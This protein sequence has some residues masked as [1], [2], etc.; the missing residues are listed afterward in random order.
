MSVDAKQLFAHIQERRSFLCVGL[1]TDI[2]RIPDCLA[3]K[4]DPIF[5]FN[6]AIIDA[7][8]D[9]CVAYK[10]NLAFYESLGARGWESLANT[11]RYIRDRY[12]KH[13]T[14]AD[15]KRGDIAST[16]AM[17]ARSIFQHL[18][19]DAVTIAPYMGRDAVQPFLEYEGRWTI[20]L[21][22]TSND[23]HADFQLLPTTV[24]GEEAP[25][26]KRV[27]ERSRTWGH[28]GNMMYV[29]GATRAEMLSEIRK[30]LP[31][32]FLLVPGVGHQ[33]GSLDEVV[34]HGMNH[35]CG[36]LINSA[37]GILYADSSSRFAEVARER[38][39]ALQTSMA[40]HL[41]QRHLL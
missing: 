24:G 31:E 29:V 41:E 21:A 11:V 12:P 36:L 7:T 14:I 16:A 27:I 10:P 8:A 38:A 2:K 39:Q 6:K 28:D 23:S 3:G 33:G 37:R 13:L 32:H 40:Q 20:L 17:Y 5:E 18:G 19:F 4:R 26:Y 22:L 15:A 1:D 9:L 25:L 34:A 30:L 35:R